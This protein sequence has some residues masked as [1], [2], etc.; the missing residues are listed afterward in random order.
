[1]DCYFI[2]HITIHDRAEYKRYEEGFGLALAPFNATVLAVDDLPTILEGEFPHD[3]VVLVRFGSQESA[4]QWYFSE[5][6]QKLAKLRW[7]VSEADIILAEG[8]FSEQ[9]GRSSSGAVA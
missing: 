6:Y 1:M 3:R 4:K 7:K 8:R 2:A 5:E 9:G